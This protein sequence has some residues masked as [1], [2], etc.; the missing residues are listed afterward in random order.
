VNGGR[1]FLLTNASFMWGRCFQIQKEKKSL[2]S[3]KSYNIINMV[4]KEGF[5]IYVT[6]KDLG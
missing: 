5:C 4:V 3:L 2:H 6:F 1:S